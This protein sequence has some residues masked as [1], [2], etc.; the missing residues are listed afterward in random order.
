MDPY[1]CA[2]VR[3][4]PPM[5]GFRFRACVMRTKSVHLTSLKKVCFRS[6]GVL[7]TRYSLSRWT[8]SD[9]KYAK[10]RGSTQG[11]KYNI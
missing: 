3:H 2:K 5:Q 11:Y 6:L 10:T 7:A 1:T 4:D 8:D 9:A